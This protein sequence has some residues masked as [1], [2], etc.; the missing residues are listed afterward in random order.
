VVPVRDEP[1]TGGVTG[2]VRAWINNRRRQS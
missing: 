2:G 1:G